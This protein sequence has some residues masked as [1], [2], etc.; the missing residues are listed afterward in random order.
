MTAKNMY[1]ST[2]SMD[3]ES[4]KGLLNC[5]E[6][7]GIGKSAGQPY[8]T[9]YDSRDYVRNSEPTIGDYTADV[10]LSASSRESYP[11][12]KVETFHPISFTDSTLH[13]PTMFSV[14][15]ND[16]GLDPADDQFAYE[17]NDQQT[18]DRIVNLR[19]NIR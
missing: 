1:G 8:L 15:L 6:Y 17:E 10:A 2:Y 5:R 13:K 11:Y 16:T 19:K 4:L 14:R 7:I 12:Q 3:M 18:A 9:Y